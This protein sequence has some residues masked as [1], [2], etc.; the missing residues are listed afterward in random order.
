[1]TLPEATDARRARVRV[2]LGAAIVLV[3]VALGVAV[4][5][6]ALAPKGQSV[7]VA[8][9]EPLTS[10]PSTVVLVHVLGSVV[11]PGLYEL[12]DGSRSVDAIAAAGGFLDTA[13]K[14]SLNLAR[15]V[16]DGEQLY[17]PAIGEAPPPMANG[18]A[19][20]KVNLNTADEAAL[21]TLPRVGPATASRIIQWRESNGRFSAI[22]DLLNVPGI[23][24]K[25]FD[26]LK[27][28][29]TV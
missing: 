12:T 17:V 23:G 24:E 1:M 4:L 3:L 10:A 15:P 8:E 26:G 20:D 6:A 5:V 22:E 2:R 21:D 11:Q 9:P 27:D 29:V 28:L 13:D 19:S 7:T 16:S 25:T 14:A 18:S